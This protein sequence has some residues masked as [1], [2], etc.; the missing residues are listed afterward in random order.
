MMHFCSFDPTSGQ[1][2]QIKRPLPTEGNEKTDR[3]VKKN[4]NNSIVTEPSKSDC[5]QIAEISDKQNVSKTLSKP[6]KPESEKVDNSPCD[7]QV[8]TCPGCFYPCEKCQS[9]K[10][11]IHC[12]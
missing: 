3:P 9:T 4:L 6:T 10:C 1:S 12:R 11:G 7:C 2:V 8:A 5:P